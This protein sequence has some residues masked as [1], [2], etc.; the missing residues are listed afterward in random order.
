M[1]TKTD[2]LFAA[3]VF[4]DSD[5]QSDVKGES[6]VV[7]QLH[8]CRQSSHDCHNTLEN[9]RNSFEFECAF[10][11]C[12]YFSRMQGDSKENNFNESSCMIEAM[13]RN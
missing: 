11:L 8:V 12:R 13:T 5:S 2:G 6:F 1:I 7:V 9:Q 10:Y 4:S 3:L